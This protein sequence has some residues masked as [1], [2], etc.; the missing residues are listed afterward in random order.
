MRFSLIRVSAAFF[1]TLFVLGLKKKIRTM[2]LFVIRLARARLPSPSSRP[3]PLLSEVRNHLFLYLLFRTSEC[4][5]A[6][7]GKRNSNECV[8][9]KDGMHPSSRSQISAVWAFSLTT[10]SLW[11]SCAVWRNSQN[12]SSLQTCRSGKWQMQ[13]S[14]ARQGSKYW[15]NLS[16]TSILSGK[17]IATN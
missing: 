12:E 15:H 10:T 11:A 5:Y 8:L 17:L 1:L 7:L 13:K 14:R 3:T 16:Q 4:A 2:Q 6:H 9:H